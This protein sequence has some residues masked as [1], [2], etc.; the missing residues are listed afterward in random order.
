M[1]DDFWFYLSVL[2]KHLE[3]P[4]QLT[5]EEFLVALG[6]GDIGVALVK[7]LVDECLGHIFRLLY[8]HV[9]DLVYHLLGVDFRLVQKHL[10][11]ALFRQRLQL[12]FF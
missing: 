5:S 9:L 3:L 10:V 11:D 1:G 4:G 2:D 6:L 12:D 8:N 7:H